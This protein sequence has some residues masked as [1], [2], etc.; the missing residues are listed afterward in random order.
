ME[1]VI[2]ISPRPKVFSPTF[3]CRLAEAN[4][5]MRQLRGLGVRVISQAVGDRDK[6]TEIVVDRNPHRTLA[7]CPNVHVTCVP[8]GY[9]RLA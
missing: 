5:A 9:G 8:L 3:L 6:P 4:R 2:Q 7:G 1:N